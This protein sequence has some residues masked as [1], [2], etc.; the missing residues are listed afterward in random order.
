MTT[1]LT[2]PQRLAALR[3]AMQQ[4]HI[5]ACLIPSSDP[6]LSEYLPAYWQARQWLSGFHGSMGTLIVTHTRPACG[7][8]AAT[9]NRPPR[10]WTAAAS[11]M[12]IQTA[13][14]TQHL[15]W[16]AE[17]LQAGKPWQWQGMC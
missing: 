12:K 13:A 10:S 14:S 9:G 3:Q 4:Q 6:H 15:D 17:N 2:I 7:P 1:L 5:D 8:T 16:L 11:L